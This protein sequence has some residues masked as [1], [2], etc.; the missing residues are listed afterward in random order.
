MSLKGASVS[1]IKTLLIM[2]RSKLIVPFIFSFFLLALGVL[3]WASFRYDRWASIQLNAFPLPLDASAYGFVTQQWGFPDPGTAQP[4]P[5]FLAQSLAF[6]AEAQD[7]DGGWGAGLHS[8]QDIRD[9]HAVTT[10][11][12]TT[13][14][15]A[16]AYLRSGSDLQQGAYRDNLRQATNYLLAAV[17]NT[18]PNAGN[19]TELTGTQPQQKLGANVDVALTAQFLARLIPHTEQDPA[20]QGRVLAALD[21]C[22]AMLEASQHEDGSWNARG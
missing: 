12:A 13:A 19:I 4:I 7:E 10:D 15:V 3:S 20:L 21:H 8:R 22:V 11:P 1:P 2:R 14:M 9:P 18:S 16:M 5:A 6:L 17:E